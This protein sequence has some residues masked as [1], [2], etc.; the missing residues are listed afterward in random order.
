[1]HGAFA[2]LLLDR[3]ALIR[4]NQETEKMTTESD[5][6]LRAMLELNGQWLA[7]HLEKLRELPGASTYNL[8]ACLFRLRDLCDEGLRMI[9]PAARAERIG[10][11]GGLN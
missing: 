9:E 3:H 5:D 1:M 7:E 10:H 8:Y 11:H 2:R 6:R 4:H